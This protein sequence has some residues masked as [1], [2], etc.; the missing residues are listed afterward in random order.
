MYVTAHYIDEEFA[1]FDRTLYVKPVRDESYI[2][3]MVLDEFK[4]ALDIF[5]IKDLIFDKIIVMA[6]CGSNIVAE[7]GIPNEFDL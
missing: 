1:M 4:E 7:D 5:G 6:D 2:A 3:V